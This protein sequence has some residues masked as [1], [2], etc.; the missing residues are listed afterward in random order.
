MNKVGQGRLYN[1]LLT[2]HGFG[3]LKVRKSSRQEGKVYG[4]ICYKKMKENIN[5][6]MKKE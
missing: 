6:G 4:K 1:T 2:K 3:D 5:L